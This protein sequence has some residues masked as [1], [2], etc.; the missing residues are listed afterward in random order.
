MTKEKLV[1]LKYLNR[2]I[3]N[4][5][6]E[7]VKLKASRISDDCII[8]GEQCEEEIRKRELELERRIK[9]SKQLKN[10][11]LEFI[12]GIDDCLTRQIF[13]Y[14]Y[15]KCLSWGGVACMTGGYNS[16]DGVRKIAERYLKKLGEKEK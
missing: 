14:R 11:I 2:A 4:E 12:D 6:N 7:L 1:Q 5:T 15:I 9:Q 10:E 16:E 3:I 8:Y 13:I